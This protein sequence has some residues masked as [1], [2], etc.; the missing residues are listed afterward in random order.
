MTDPDPARWR[1]HHFGLPAARWAALEGRSFWITGAGTGYGRSLACALAAAG[2]QVIL[3]GRRRDKLAESLAAMEKLGISAA[4]C[5]IVTADLTDRQQVNQAAHLVMR[6]CPSLHGLI[7]NA[8]LPS[9]PGSVS[10]LQNDPPEYW[11]RMLATNLTAPWLLTRAVLPHL[12]ASGS[13]RVLF[14]SSGAGWAATPG[15]GVYNLTKAALNSLGHSLAQE[16]ARDHP[17][18]DLQV[19]VLAAG[20]ARTEMNQGSD[21]TPFALAGMALALLSHP[22]GGPNGRFFT[23]DGQHLAFGHTQPH[24]APLLETSDQTQ[25]PTQGKRFFIHQCL[26]YDDGPADLRCLQALERFMIGGGGNLATYGAGRLSDYLLRHCPGLASRVI[27]IIEDESAKLG[28]GPGG[29][30]V[31][32]LDKTPVE[33]DTVF[34][35]STRALSLARMGKRLLGLGRKL[36][37]FTLSA[38]EVVD[39]A[40]IP[41]R[42]WRDPIPGNCPGDLPDIGFEPDKDVILLELP[43]RYM[44]MIPYGLGHVHNI[45]KAAGADVQTMDLNIIF[46]HRYHAR[47]IL[48]GEERGAWPEGEVGDGDPWQSSNTDQWSDPR[49]L[50]K[51]RPDL[52]EVIAG[53]IAARPRILGLSLNGNNGLLAEEVIRRVKAELP[54]TLILV[55]GYDCVYRDLALTKVE[56]YDYMFVG[57]T[58]LTLGPVVR[59]LLAGQRPRDLPGVISRFDSPQREWQAAPLPTD[60]DAFDFPRYEWTDLN[61][62]RDR[63]GMC[64]TPVAGSRGCH[65]GRCN[66]CAERFNWRRRQPDKVVDEIQWHAQQ[67][68]EVFHFNESDV[69]GDPNHLLE[70]CRE[71]IRRGLDVKLYG[72]MRIDPRNDLEFFHTIKQA[73]FTVLRFGVDGWTDH[74]LRLQRKGYSMRT[75]EQNLR[76]CNRAGL[77][78]AVNMVIGVPGETEA[79]VEESVRNIT[80]LRHLLDSISTINMLILANGSHYYMNPEQHHIR[81]RGDRDQIFREHPLFIPDQLWYSEEPYIDHQ[82]RWERFIRILRA[83]YDHGAPLGEYAKWEVVKE[84]KRQGGRLP[85]SFDQAVASA[86]ADGGEPPPLQ[87]ARVRHSHGLHLRNQSR[88]Q[89]ALTELSMASQLD[90]ANPRFLNSLAVAQWETGQAEQAQDSLRRSLAL[91]PR[92]TQAMLNLALIMEAMGRRGEAMSALEEFLGQGGDPILEHELDRLREAV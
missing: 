67:G 54:E 9:R 88:R 66:F 90:P 49:A 92:H 34:L 23:M 8:A 16:L 41:A 31:T 45:L 52:E 78:A 15:L 55:G 46:Y 27:C 25:D 85:A 71:I 50:E 73:G 32:P 75:V 33:V 48:D 42:A 68:F 2:G 3:T 63:H 91:D 79:D 53:L 19:N 56:L 30:P 39:K 21:R 89:E 77:L 14:I 57:E 40:A 11:D 82:V 72:Q 64:S 6:L 18:L 17:G 28:T 81:F 61:L 87:S 12:L 26:D 35:G 65:W 37:L 43:P 58:E 69:N 7:N 13:P 24:P 10:P 5:Q 22:A 1:E 80:R 51:F 47:R 4:R 20:E 38:I 62:Y 70:I 74:V 29:I 76:D 86:F 59:A 36:R 83:L 44:P 60:L 84:A